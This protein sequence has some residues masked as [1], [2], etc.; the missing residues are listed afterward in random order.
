MHFQIQTLSIQT[1]SFWIKTDTELNR[2]I[3]IIKTM[4]NFHEGRDTPS[5]HSKTNKM[6]KK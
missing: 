6:Q 2:V 3:H 4:I 5:R 1:R